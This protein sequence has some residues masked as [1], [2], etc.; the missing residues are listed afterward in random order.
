MTCEAL[1]DLDC[2][3]HDMYA[4][5]N[6]SE[7][8]PILIFDAQP[9]ESYRMSSAVK[10]SYHFKLQEDLDVKTSL[11]AKNHVQRRAFVAGKMTVIVL[12]M[13]SSD[14]KHHSEELETGQIDIRRQFAQLK[15]DQQP[16]VD[17]VTR[18]DD[19]SLEPETVVAVMLPTDPIMHL[20]HLIDPEVHYEILSKRGLTRSG[21]TTPPSSVV[22]LLL[23][24][25]E[26]DNPVSLKK[27]IDRMMES[28]DTHR[29]PFIVKLQQ[30][31][32]GMGNLVARCDEDRGP[33][34]K[35]LETQMSAMLRQINP[36]NYHLHPCS[37][38]LQDYIQGTDVALSLF[39]TR[40]GRPIFVGC[41]DQRFDQQGHWDG[42]TISY[43]AQQALDQKYAKTVEPVARFL[44]GEGYYGPAGVDIV[45]DNRGIHHVVDLNPRITGTYHLGLLAGHFTKRGL[46]TAAVVSGY[47]SSSRAVFEDAFAREIRDGSL[48][49]TGWTHHC[50]M[51]LSCAAITVGGRHL[52]EMEKL[53]ARVCAFAS[54]KP[55]NML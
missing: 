37:L 15:R 29:M 54:L 53:A 10:F 49:I 48:I 8:Q 14:S 25:E 16:T 31:V 35:I 41:C 23:P 40:K 30:T 19:V 12:E 4:L 20:P 27:E 34:K 39:V 33:I 42:G 36:A 45:T 1:I 13:G 24:L 38:V 47:F 26:L 55:P 51:M 52:L 6:D 9:L 17:F 44:H 50:T 22:D 18:L 28:I 32:S 21:L 5:D 11:L 46:R 2:T 43:G 3:L 7:S